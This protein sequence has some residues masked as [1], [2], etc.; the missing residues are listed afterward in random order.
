[1]A[2]EPK[3]RKLGISFTPQRYE[4]TEGGFLIHAFPMLAEG[5]WSD[6]SGQGPLNYPARSLEKYATNWRENIGWS[7]HTGG[8]PRSFS[9]RVSEVRSLR[10]DPAAKAIVGDVFYHGLTQA[11]RDVI[12]LTKAD[13]AAGRPV[14][15]SVEVIT[16]E[17]YNETSRLMEAEKL[18]F[19]GYAHVSQGACRK[20]RVNEALEIDSISSLE[21]SGMETKEIEDKLACQA[22]QLEEAKRE[23]AEVKARP[24]VSTEQVETK[25][26]ELSEA[27]NKSD[28]T[29]AEQA[30]TIKELSEKVKKLEAL[31]A[32][33]KSS[34]P[35]DREERDVY[36]I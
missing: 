1:M 5:T 17:R 15:V 30:V 6:S 12:A 35:Q 10:Y 20:C 4:D 7:R 34:V 13:L 32:G 2:T 33:T 27:L 28:K 36:I 29:I 8:V 22:K 19:T 23:L 25:I 26:K 16:E 9:D 14:Y 3:T 11:S 21:G 18:T 24:V 31:P